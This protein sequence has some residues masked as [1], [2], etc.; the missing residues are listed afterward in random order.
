MRAFLSTLTF[1]HPIPWWVFALLGCAALVVFFRS[2]RG[3]MQEVSRVPRYSI[4]ALRCL[5][6]LILF[7]CAL[8]PA[9]PYGRDTLA[10]GA[11]RLYLFVDASDSMLRADCGRGPVT[12]H[13]LAVQ[14][15][16]RI[17][18]ATSGYD[19]HILFFDDDVHSAAPG[20]PIHAARGVR[21]TGLTAPLR[22]LLTHPTPPASQAVVLSDG[23]HAAEEDITPIAS[24]Y[25]VAGQTPVH[26]TLISD[27]EPTPRVAVAAMTLPSHCAVNDTV[28]CAV[29]IHL[30]DVTEDATVTLFRDDL[31]IATQSVSPT[32]AVHHVRFALTPTEHGTRTY[33]VQVTAPDAETRAATA[34]V[35]LQ[36]LRRTFRVLYIEG[37]A[38]N[39]Y[40]DTPVYRNVPD[41]LNLVDDIHCDVMVD[42]MVKQYLPHINERLVDC[43][44][45]GYPLTLEGLAQY[46][47]VINSDIARSRFTREQIDNTAELVEQRGGGY[48]MI[49]G[50]T[51]FARGGW[52]ETRIERISP[53]EM[54]EHR[55]MDGAF[56][57][58][59]TP[60]GFRHPIMQFVDDPEENARI[61]R[62]MP[63]F[64]GYNS[65]RRIKP[66]AVLLATHPTRLTDDNEKMPMLAVQEMGRGR[67]MAFMS[68][69]TWLWGMDFER[70][71]GE[72]IDAHVHQRDN[73]YYAQFWQ[74]SVRWLGR[75]SLRHYLAMRYITP[76]NQTPTPGET[77]RIWYHDPGAHALASVPRV[78][79]RV[80]Q[81][82]TEST[83]TLQPMP[84]RDAFYTDITVATTGRVALVV[85]RADDADNPVTY[86]LYARE[87]Y[88][89]MFDITPT[90]DYLR[91]ISTAGRGT[92]V[93]HNEPLAL[94]PPPD[95]HTRRA[96]TDMLS[97]VWT[98]PWLLA[99]LLLLFTCEWAIRRAS[100]MA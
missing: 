2:L 60:E 13:D 94:P 70:H 64:Y 63:P 82:E 26:T 45:E 78:S 49:G 80:T 62:S 37:T 55:Y 93:M 27:V 23:T 22:Y 28:Y 21:S 81:N 52:H 91:M 86:A 43:P 47:V 77:V 89:E 31:P 44:R 67:C 25:R 20:T 96:A 84:E 29:E 100:G 12:R 76:D 11:P 38:V 3:Q 24:R 35:A 17:A 61:I 10:R 41:A 74:N 58:E 65:S 8:R 88:R 85:T 18:R 5:I 68:D 7:L 97:D 59:F 53:I 33:T 1:L 15:A 42:P 79:L 30:A 75:N 40:D 48:V 71:W 14:A 98:N 16:T 32:A 72:P 73:R 19:T 9:L 69:T 51:A 34:S 95:M 92:H 4:V 66:T 57:W 39:M 6:I 83:Y 87:P 54:G 56:V 90:A 50:E 36:V 46:D 99:L